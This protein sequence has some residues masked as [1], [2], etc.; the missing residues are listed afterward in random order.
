MK[1]IQN[2]LRRI[3]G[4]I[5]GLQKILVDSPDDC[6]KVITQ[7][8]AAQSALDNCFATLLNEHL[9]GCI[10]GADSQKM[11]KILKLITKQ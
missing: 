7:F 8:K 10:N 11:E 2:R 4:Q 1:N 5:R 3:E 6:E 9:R